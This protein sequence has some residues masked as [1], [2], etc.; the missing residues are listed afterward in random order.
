METSEIAH[1]VKVA[2]GVFKERVEDGYPGLEEKERI[3]VRMSLT[4]I[5]N[6]LV[7][8]LKAINQADMDAVATI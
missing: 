2:L 8:I 1:S 5:L 6:Q 3:D 7:D 4:S